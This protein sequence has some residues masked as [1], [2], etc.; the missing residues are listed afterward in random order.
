MHAQLEEIFEM[1]GI[2]DVLRL[3]ETFKRIVP[4]ASKYNLRIVRINVR[5]YPGSSPWSKDEID[6]IREKRENAKDLIVG[7]GQELGAF[8]TWFIKTQNIPA[9]SLNS[10]RHESGG[11]SVLSWSLG[12]SLSLSLLAHVDKL[13]DDSKDLLGRYLRSIILLGER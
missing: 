9:L 2:T 4:F 3:A 12:N 13:S 8:V 1:S 11:V 7:M 10:E 5:D 6:T